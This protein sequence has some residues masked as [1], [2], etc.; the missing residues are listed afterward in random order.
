MGVRFELTDG[1]TVAGFQDRCLRPL[2]QPTL[3]EIVY[4]WNCYCNSQTIGFALKSRPIKVNLT[5]P[6]WRVAGVAERVRLLSEC[7]G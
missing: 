1:I 2:D 3:N 5:I 4:R 6:L 7:S